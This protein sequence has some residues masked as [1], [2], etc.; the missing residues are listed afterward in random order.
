MNIIILILLNYISLSFQIKIESAIFCDDHLEGV[1]SY[2]EYTRTKKTQPY[3]D[4][5]HLCYDFDLVNLDVDPGDKITIQC[6]NTGG[7]T[8][9]GGCFLI[10]NNCNCY[11]FYMS[12]QSYGNSEEPLSFSVRFSNNKV[13]NYDMKYL[14][15]EIVGHNEFYFYL[16]LNTN[17]ISCYY[18]TITAPTNTKLYLRFSDYIKASF[19]F[20]NLKIKV[21]NNYEY[22]KLNNQQLSSS[23][24]F[25]ILNKLEYF[26][27]QSSRITVN[28]DL[29]DVLENGNLQSNKYCG[30]YIRFCYDSCLDCYDKEPNDNSHQCSKCKDDYYFIEN[31]NNCMTKKQMENNHTYYFDNKTEKFKY[32]YNSCEECYN[33]E[34]NETSHQCSKCKDD[35]YF[36]ENT[37]NCLSIN[38]A[39]NS[40]YYFDDKN[41][42]FKSCYES[43]QRCNDTDPNGISHQCSECK[44]DFYFIEN[45]SN[46]TTKIEMENSHYYFDNKKQQFRQCYN[47]C[48][49][50]DNET[51]CTNCADGYH[52]IYNERGKCISEPNK[53]DLL[54]LDNKTNTYIKCP[55]ETESENNTNNGREQDQSSKGNNIVLIIVLTVVSLIIIIV[56]FFFIK[57]YIARKKFESETSTLLDEDKNKDKDPK[58]NQLINVFL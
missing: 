4:Q 50:C 3:N 24:Q 48:S 8:H 49:T 58:D 21:Y 52:F 25:Y 36:I 26:S 9:G 33:I 13:C 18:K 22:F 7:P 27:E 10:N 53:E 37:F 20:T 45:T 39:K 57:R 32:C 31:T 44:E 16:P 6:H 17:E 19:Q 55:E 12:G 34:S 35:Y 47:E 38:D 56:L 42:T 51:H 23:T 14:I 46:C 54:C 2:S 5:G 43:C 29:Y 11:H 1:Y 40:P 30:F 15:N 28:F 41:N